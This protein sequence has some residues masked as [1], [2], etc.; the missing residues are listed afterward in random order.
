MFLRSKVNFAHI[1]IF[2][3]FP[4]ENSKIQNWRNCTVHL[5]S[6]VHF[7]ELSKYPMQTL[8]SMSCILQYFSKNFA[9]K[10]SFTL[11]IIFSICIFSL[12]HIL[13]KK[14]EFKRQFVEFTNWTTTPRFAIYHFMHK[15]S[16]I[17]LTPFN[18][19]ILPRTAKWHRELIA[20]QFK[21][22]LCSVVY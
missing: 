16:I 22:P 9:M 15:T 4:L 1:H 6:Q 2:A 5:T 17:S 3:N 21:V 7:K 20:C 11:R 12:I 10:N 8:L 14:E 13:F 18:L 19:E